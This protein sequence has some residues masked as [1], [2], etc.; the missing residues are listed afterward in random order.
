MVFGAVNPKVATRLFDQ[1]ND[2][3]Q[4]SRVPDA[5]WNRMV[6]ASSETQEVR[7]LLG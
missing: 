5:S 3:A 4:G 7:L 1:L 2:F 6:A